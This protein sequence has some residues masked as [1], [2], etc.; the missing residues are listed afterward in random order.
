[1]ATRTERGHPVKADVLVADRPS[2]GPRRAHDRGTHQRDEAD[3]ESGL[4]QGASARAGS[5]SE[6]FHF[7]RCNSGNRSEH[8]KR[9]RKGDSDDPH[10]RVDD[11]RLTARASPLSF[12][13]LSLPSS[14]A[15][16]TRVKV[17]CSVST[18]GRS[19]FFVSF[20]T[21]ERRVR[22]RF[23]LTPCRFCRFPL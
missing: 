19:R 22:R 16:L 10:R 21:N 11:T 1:M 9:R 6:L 2:K 20:S 17:G 5:D 15:A 7:S 18:A 23:L 8:D 4:L 13:L 14:L 3:G 12:S